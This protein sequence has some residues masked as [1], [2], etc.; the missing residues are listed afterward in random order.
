M[1][2]GVLMDL[3]TFSFIAKDEYIEKAAK[4]G[5]DVCDRCDVV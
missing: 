1:E 2:G 4:G 3:T 5:C